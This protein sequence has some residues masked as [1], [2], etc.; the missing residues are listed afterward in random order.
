MDEVT[1]SQL[2]ELIRKWG[3]SASKRFADAKFERDPMGKRLIE[4]GAVVLYNCCRDLEGLL[5]AEQ[6]LQAKL[7]EDCGQQLSQQNGA[8]HPHDDAVFGIC[9]IGLGGK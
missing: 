7:L 2:A 1:R 8:D 5:L 3:T 4:H 9:H 6:A